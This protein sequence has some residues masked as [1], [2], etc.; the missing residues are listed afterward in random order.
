M[1]RWLPSWKQLLSIFLIFFGGG[2]AA[3]GTAYAMTSVPDPKSMVNNQPNIYYWA[4]GSE[5]TRTGSLTRQVVPIGDINRSAQDA[6]IAAENESFRTD[7]G[8]DPKGIARAVYNMASGQATQGGSTIT[9]Q[10]V[11]NAYL[12][13]SQ[14]LSRKLK[15]FFI[16]LKI[17]Q[18]MSKD[19]I[20][21]G[22]LN[23]SW[24]GRQS[25]G[26]QAAAHNYYNV[27]AKD[28]NVCQSAMLAGLLKGAGLYDPSLSAANHA[29]MFGAPTDPRAV[30]A[31]GTS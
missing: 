19:D 30:A 9:Q 23:T 7:P 4:D 13:Q 1:R 25:Y 5:M 15:E 24:F 11:K 22:Y 2:V 8:I 14:T 10:Y 27:D 31:G 3:V 18:K 26:I 21:D 6:V 29:R 20:L 12:N 16:T 17:N 28:L